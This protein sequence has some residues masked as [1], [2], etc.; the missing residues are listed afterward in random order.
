[1]KF[2]PYTDAGVEIAPGII[3]RRDGK[4]IADLSGSTGIP[5][6]TYVGTAPPPAPA[7]N[8]L[9]WKSDTGVLYVYYNDGTSSQWVPASPP[10]PAPAGSILQVQTA[11]KSDTFTSAATAY[12]DVPGL[13]VTLTPRNANSRFRIDVALGI[14]VATATY[15]ASFQILRNGVPINNAPVAGLRPRGNFNAAIASNTDHPSGTAY[16]TVDVPALAVP[17]T[18]KLQV[19]TQAGGTVFI[20]RS[21]ND[22]DG[23]DPYQARAT[24]N[25]TVMEVAG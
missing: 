20:N 19:A 1:M 24:S 5:L 14:A 23:A 4:L 22:T 13:S 11:L 2:S 10:S 9:W 3:M 18:Y 17:L 12:T 15:G 25:F 8:Q 7:A 21:Q 6:G 16:H